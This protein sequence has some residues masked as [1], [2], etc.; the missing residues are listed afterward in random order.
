MADDNAIGAYCK[1]LITFLP[2]IPLAFIVNA[3]ESGFADHTDAGPETLVVP[4]DYPLDK[5]YIPTDHHIKRP[6]LIAASIA[7]GTGLKPLM[8]V[9][10]FTIEWEP[11]FWGYEV[12]K[13]IFKYQEHGFITVQ[14]LN[15]GETR[16]LCLTIPS[17]E[18]SRTT[19]AWGC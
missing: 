11:Y 19:P 8:I 14:L 18:G 4:V 9:P 2:G 5:M 13:M 7:D 1:C 12:T 16:C 6:T 15:K 10:R 3:N 17:S